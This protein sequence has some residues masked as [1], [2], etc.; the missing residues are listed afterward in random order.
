M[1]TADQLRQIAPLLRLGAG[2]PDLVHTQVR[3]RAYESP[4][5]AEARTPPPWRHNGP[6]TEP[7]GPTQLLLHRD[8]KEP[9]LPHFGP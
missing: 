4:T 6:E 3:V 2:A 8:A 9:E 5:A 1:L 7:G